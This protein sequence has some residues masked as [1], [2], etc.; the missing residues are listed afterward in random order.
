MITLFTFG[1]FLGSPDSSPFVT[2]AMALLAMAGA[3]Y[4]T[5][6]GLPF[7]GPH[8]FL[9]YI[10]DDGV[11]VPD[12]DLIRAHLERRLG[13]DFD[14]GLAPAER[15]AARAMA[16]MCEDHL[17]FAMLSERWQVDAIFRAGL[18]RH[19]FGQVPAPARPL[20]KWVLR[21]M[22]ARRLRG[23]GLGRHSRADLVNMGAA[24]LEALAAFLGDKP[25]LMGAAPCGA[26]ASVFGLVDAVLTPPLATP[27]RDAALRHANLVAYR[28]RFA[29]RFFPE[30]S[31]A[32][33]RVA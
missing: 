11:K 7:A 8:G 6:V 24:D 20:A 3:P 19:M 18:G 32:V 27:L 5:E 26:D 2:K 17:Y 12:S 15:G 22:N 14:A 23:Q 1:P 4:R 9:P 13:I 21:R 10:V 16:R 29:R 25:F 30:L 31:D 28:E 33:R